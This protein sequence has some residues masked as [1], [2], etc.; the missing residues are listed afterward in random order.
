MLILTIAGTLGADPE[1]RTT[2]SG[3]T[4]TSFRVAVNGYDYGKREKTTTWVRVTMWGERGVKLGQMLSKGDKLCASGEGKLSTYT[5]KD[6]VQ[7]T[8][9]EL[10]ADQLSPMG[11]GQKRDDEPRK[12]SKQKLFEKIEKAAEFPADDDIPF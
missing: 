9:L 6:G 8:S 4:V 2:G 10:S 5:D 1:T 12:S 11:G 7:R 3:K